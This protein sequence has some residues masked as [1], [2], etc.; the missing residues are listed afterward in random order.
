MH[1]KVKLTYL[2]SS[3]RNVWNNGTHKRNYSYIYRKN[4]AHNHDISS[5]QNNFHRNKNTRFIATHQ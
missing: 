1:K 5:Y 3:T 2:Y 4:E